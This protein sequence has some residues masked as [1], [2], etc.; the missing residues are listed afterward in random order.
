MIHAYVKRHSLYKFLK[1]IIELELKY[2]F[3]HRSL[4][5]FLHSE[6]HKNEMMHWA[7]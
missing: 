6:G 5:L 7:Q 4:M 2:I 3:W 1:N